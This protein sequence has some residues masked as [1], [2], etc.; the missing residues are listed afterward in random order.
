M[1]ERNPT[2]WVKTSPEVRYRALSGKRSFDAIVI[3]GGIAG[4]SAAYMLQRDRMKVVIGD[5]AGLRGIRYD[6]E[7]RPPMATRGRGDGEALS[8][9]IEARPAPANPR[10]VGL[11]GARRGSPDA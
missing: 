11:G 1:N 10:P 7:A 4:L 6:D 9:A 2:L 8:G 5:A 3:G